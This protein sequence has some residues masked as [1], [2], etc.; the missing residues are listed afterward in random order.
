MRVCSVCQKRHEEFE[1]CVGG[2]PSDS[3]PGFYLGSLLFSGPAGDVHRA[4]EVG[5]GRSCLIRI[6]STDEDCAREILR[7]AELAARLF[8]PAI[9]SVY[10]A[11]RLDDG[12]C[13][14][15]SEDIEGRTLRE[16]L[17]DVGIP[18]LLDTIEI[19]RQT[20]EALHSLHAAGLM[21]GALN[22]RNIVLSGNVERALVRLHPHDLGRARQ[23]SII[24]NR[25]VID[26]ELDA[27]RYFAPEQCAGGET[28]AQS[29]GYSLGVVFYELLAGA[30]PFDASTA[31]G[32]IHQHKNLPPPEIK[33]GN[34]NLRML[35]THAL[36][37]ALQKHPRLRQPSAGTFARQ[38][39]HI[40]QLATHSSTPPPACVVAETPVP[41][42]RDPIPVVA[43]PPSSVEPA[44]TAIVPERP[45]FVTPRSR[46]KVWKKKLHTIAARLATETNAQVS[47][48]FESANREISDR[49][50]IA[51]S[52]VETR[53]G[54]N[55][56]ARRKAER[57]TPEDSVPSEAAPREILEREG[58]FAT[59]ERTVSRKQEAIETPKVEAAA[60]IPT[61]ENPPRVM[62][63]E[64]PVAIEPSLP[65]DA[66]VAAERPAT[67]ETPITDKPALENEA[68][69]TTD[70]P[71]ADLITRTSE[72]PVQIKA[73]AAKMPSP[74]VRV[75]SKEKVPVVSNPK[76]SNDRRPV[77]KS[78]LGF[79]VDLAQLEE[80]TLVRPPGNRLQIHLDDT[81]T[82]RVLSAPRKF[83]PR[84]P[85]ETG[86]FPTLLGDVRKS[87][88]VEPD[89]KGT[90]FSDHYPVAARPTTTT[91]NRYLLLGGGFVALLALMLFGNDSAT[92]LFQTSSSAD[93]VT[94]NTLRSTET[95]PEA[96]PLEQSRPI[97][98]KNS[99][100][101]P[102]NTVS[103]KTPK[104]KQSVLSD[105]PV[106]AKRPASAPLAKKTSEAKNKKPAAER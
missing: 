103:V 3:I 27:L 45:I 104:E 79:K 62:V 105:V 47:S 101:A 21:H 76:L 30:P 69:V 34:F 4:R 29:D 96:R 94:I 102:S 24:A 11:G 52:I 91:R 82:K 60:E 98:L 38:L 87:E 14:I 81:A 12:R 9:A 83:K 5:S 20:A 88:A 40:E 28:S 78:G 74:P 86:F 71:V 50:S 43:P 63:V 97:A 44:V 48:I 26:S 58:K 25:F 2:T 56:K 72:A 70:Q 46:L 73:P 18:D 42:K 106:A 99:E 39:R 90:M 23:R 89:Q 41:K 13:F 33:I 95:S 7:E 59:Q 37:E 17:D 16:I 36:T 32:L 80:I 53:S 77:K 61:V 84:V 85:E 100:K 64:T 19:V 65:Y 10:D 15:V 35:V 22:P 1:A 54:D 93:S 8:H 51:P 31:V 67:I 75:T 57:E 68:H 55:T 49:A 6:I 66:P 92:K